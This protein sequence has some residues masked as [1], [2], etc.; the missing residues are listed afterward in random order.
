M[1]EKICAGLD[2]NVSRSDAVTA[3]LYYLFCQ[4]ENVEIP[5]SIKPLVER[6]SG[7]APVVDAARELSMLRS[8]LTSMKRTL[9]SM[10]TSLAEM[11]GVLIWLLGEKLGCAGADA[12]S[13]SQGLNLAFY[14]SELLRGRVA[15][16]SH[17]RE[18]SARVAKG[19]EIEDAKFRS[20]QKNKK[21]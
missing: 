17:E 1:Q 5:D 16:Q 15:A 21:Q 10:Q 13:G 2:Y 6:V 11:Y 18:V 4:D 7:G 19:R 8:E 12:D 20:S 3:Y 9:S 14:D